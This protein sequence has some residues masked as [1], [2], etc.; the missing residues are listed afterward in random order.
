MKKNYKLISLILVISLVMSCN[1]SKDN[2]TYYELNP[3]TK[4]I[5]IVGFDLVKTDTLPMFNPYKLEL[6]KYSSG[7]NLISLE[8][9]GNK[10]ITINLSNKN[11][12]ETVIFPEEQRKIIDFGYINEDSVFLVL[13]TVKDY[14]L[15]DSALLLANMKG[16]ILRTYNFDNAPVLTKNNLAQRYQDSAYSVT[17]NIYEPFNIVGKYVIVHLHNNAINLG[18]SRYKQKNIIGY[19][20]TKDNEYHP[21]KI[22]YPDIKYGKE[23]YPYEFTYFNSVVD[24]KKNLLCSFPNTPKIVM[25][26]FNSKK[27]TDTIIKSQIIDRLYPF[28]N[29]KSITQDWAFPYPMYM[30]IY[31]DKYR[32]YYYRL[33]KMPREYGTTYMMMVLDSNLNYIGEGFVPR[34]Y[35]PKLLFTDKYFITLGLSKD[36]KNIIVYYY[37]MGLRKGTNK[38]LIT[39]LNSRRRDKK[40]KKKNYNIKNYFTELTGEKHKNYTYTVIFYDNMC[41]S[42]RDFIFKHYSAN[43]KKYEKYG[44]YLVIITQRPKAVAEMLN[45]YNLSPEKHRNIKIDSN[46]L[47][48]KYNNYS[49]DYY[50]RVVKIRQNKVV[51]DSLFTQ[52]ESIGETWQDVLVEATEEQIKLVK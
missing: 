41:H 7:Y 16:Q 37:T 48:V 33:I 42:I 24:D 52:P 8:E 12:N 9:K 32:N 40:T 1:I 36:K 2:K 6:H 51:L 47:F 5:N 45:D 49:T 18:D 19:I 38:E 28:D 22:S 35:T 46:M 25:Y 14:G 27:Y 30:A 15:N 23:F 34:Y 17:A 43:E 11:I 3:K 29:A 39:E 31:Y 21:L 10:I 4:E 50:P 44:T 13:N 20:D 26:N